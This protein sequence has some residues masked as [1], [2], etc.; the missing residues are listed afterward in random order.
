M[1]LSSAMEGLVFVALLAIASVVLSNSAGTRNSQTNRDLSEKN[2]LNLNKKA[3]TKIQRK[4]NNNHQ[5]RDGLATYLEVQKML[6]LD[7][8][9]RISDN[10]SKRQKTSQIGYFTNSTDSTVTAKQTQTETPDATSSTTLSALDGN[11][12]STQTIQSTAQKIQ[13]R[14]ECLTATNLTEYWRLDHNGSTILPSQNPN[15]GSGYACDLDKPLDWFRF[16]GAAGKT[17]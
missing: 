3:I 8:V 13:P 10:K 17:R 11:V 5:L 4:I 12:T 1:L 14:P 2:V 6:Y 15:G 16:T 7:L 9:R